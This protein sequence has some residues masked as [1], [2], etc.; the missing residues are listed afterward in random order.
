MLT[1][2]TQ[3]LVVIDLETTGTNP[4]FHDVLAVGLVPLMQPAPPRVV[5]VRPEEPRWSRYAKVNFEKFAE[6]WESHAVPP[7]AACETIER[8]LE[9]VFHGEEVTPIGH[10]V[11]FDVAFLRKLAFLAGKD[12]LRAVSHRTLDTHTMLYLLFLNGRLPA[13][14]LSSDGASTTSASKCPRHPAILR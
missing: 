2:S 8:Y 3:N 7:E 9:E 10:N 13:S 1:L 4:F 5:Y 14:A 11:G 6:T 12:E